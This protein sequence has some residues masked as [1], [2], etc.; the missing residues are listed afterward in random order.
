MVSPTSHIIE[1]YLKFI[2]Y[3]FIFLVDL[4]CCSLV[5][6]FRLI[7]ILTTE[8]QICRFCG[9]FGLAAKTARQIDGCGKFYG[10]FVFSGIPS[11]VSSWVLTLK[12]PPKKNK[13]NS[14][15]PSVSPSVRGISGRK[16]ALT[17]KWIEAE[18]FQI[19]RGCSL[20][21]GVDPLRCPLCSLTPKTGVISPQ[22]W[23]LSI[24]EDITFFDIVHRNKKFTWYL[25]CNSYYEGQPPPA[26]LGR[27]RA[28]P[29]AGAA[30]L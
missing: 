28:R 22:F 18:L 23:H 3:F 4:L 24:S 17:K 1:V 20:E 11:C 2:L 6:I 12:S 27:G 8:R 15:S 14:V 26:L 9:K 5:H 29:S 19:L 25:K 16:S 21:I 30:P 7:L 13:C 10:K